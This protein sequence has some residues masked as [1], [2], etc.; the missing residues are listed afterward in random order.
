MPTRARG[1]RPQARAVPARYSKQVQFDALRSALN[2]EQEG[3]GKRLSPVDVATG[4]AARLR[5]QGKSTNDSLAAACWLCH[6]RDSAETARHLQE[7][8]DD[9][10][11]AALLARDR[12]FYLYATEGAEDDSKEFYDLLATIGQL[13]GD[14]EWN[15]DHFDRLEQVGTT[16]VSSP[17]SAALGLWRFG[18]ELQRGAWEIRAHTLGSASRGRKGGRPRAV[19]IEDLCKTASALRVSA[20]DLARAAAA[21]LRITG[22][23]VKLRANEDRE[24][25]LERVRAQLQQ[26]MKRAGV[27]KPRSGSRVS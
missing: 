16:Y 12:A 2:A 8:A 11:T 7:R 17:L 5:S 9:F 6:L 24:D 19:R 25:M 21:D 23:F 3:S 4:I 22:G 15:R 26:H 13:I 27:T 1:P 20:T 14:R 18:I 10:E